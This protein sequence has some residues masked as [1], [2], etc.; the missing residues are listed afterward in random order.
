VAQRKRIAK[1]VFGSACA[2]ID[3]LGGGQRCEFRPSCFLIS[4]IASD[5]SVV[6]LTNFDEQIARLM[7][8]HPSDIET[9]VRLTAT[10]DRNVKHK[11]FSNLRFKEPCLM[12]RK[13]AC[14][15]SVLRSFKAAGARPLSY[16]ETPSLNRHP[17]QTSSALAR[18]DH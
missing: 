15:R 13:G 8:R 4:Q 9:L 5:Q 12:V 6:C 1:K 16:H 11:N 17:P 2:N 14:P 10:K 3:E 18:K 7:M